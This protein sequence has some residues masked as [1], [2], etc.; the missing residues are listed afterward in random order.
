MDDRRVYV[1]FS[2]AS[3]SDF[4][5]GIFCNMDGGE[6]TDRQPASETFDISCGERIVHDFYAYLAGIE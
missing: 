2:G 6:D 1:I 3:C 5:A 4:S